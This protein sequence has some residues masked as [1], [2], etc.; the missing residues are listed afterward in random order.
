MA[1]LIRSCMR[2]HVALLAA[3]LLGVLPSAAGAQ[4]TG[5]DYEA[6]AVS[7]PATQ[8]VIGQG[9]TVE[10]TIGNG[11]ELA[12]SDLD[13][14]IVL[15]LNA[16][17][18]PTDRVIH[19]GTVA[20]IDPA[21]EL[22]Q[23][24]TIQLPADLQPGNYLLGLIVD[25]ATAHV[26]DIEANNAVASTAELLLLPPLSIQPTAMAEGQV[27]VHYCI[28]FTATGGDGTYTWSFDTAPAGLAFEVQD[29]ALLLCG[30]PAAEGTFAVGIGVESA[31]ES[32]GT[33]FAFT[34]RGQGTMPVAP[35][36]TSATL[37]RMNAGVRVE[38]QP[39]VVTGG[40]PPFVFTSVEA[41]RLAI[42]WLDARVWI[43]APP[44]GLVLTADGVVSGS[45]TEAG[46]YEWTI[47]VS[48]AVGSTATC[49]VTFDVAVE[50]ALTIGSEPLA[51]ATADTPYQ[52]T[53]QAAGGAGTVVWLDA[54]DMPDG[55]E[56]DVDGTIR[57]VIA[58]SLLEGEERRT[59]TFTVRAFD[60]QNRVAEAAVSLDVVQLAEQP[61][62]LPEPEQPT[63]PSV[64]TDE[65]SG[66]TAAA[67][68]P[69]LLAFAAL[70]LLAARRRRR[71]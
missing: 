16:I 43:Q 28:E 53:L 22:T 39:F 29:G 42:D 31:G 55:L 12:A 24:E 49:L 5:V 51:E 33:M 8:V 37:P 17:I 68:G 15:S 23:T 7:T 59:F 54:G 13:Y 47:E 52:A 35:T 2:R 9:L 19:E 34:V 48:D 46:S 1:H 10:W 60:S 36:C 40:T 66:C 70:G 25:P 38:P 20:H 63:P 32:F 57:G 21:S 71:R 64:D 41:R 6:I 50:G 4:D 18:T 67:A 27:G 62:E 11:G 61:T 65:E 44:P 30:V 56:L 58:S 69:S 45:P 3:G 26:E 14:Q